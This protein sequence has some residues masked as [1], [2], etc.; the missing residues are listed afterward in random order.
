MS[1][2]NLDSEEEV[3]LDDSMKEILDEIN[4]KDKETETE[5][6]SQEAGD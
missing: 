6:E 3:S 5:D 1:E 4:A 2:N